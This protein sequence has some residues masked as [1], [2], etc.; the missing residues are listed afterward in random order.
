MNSKTRVTLLGRLRDG[1]DPLAWDEFFGRYW[2]L[3]YGFAQHRGCS[4]HTA[5]EIVQE[6][7]LKVFDQR[8]VFQ[9]DPERGRFR[10]WL[11]RLVRNHVAEYRRKPAQRIRAQGDL[12]EP[13][14]DAAG[15]DEAWEKAFEESLLMA[16]LEVVRREANPRDYLAFELFTLQELSGAEVARITGLTRNAVY[17]ARKRVLQRLKTLSGSYPS[18]GQLG[19]RVKQALRSQPGP[20]VE[21]SLTTRIEMTARSR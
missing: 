3:I 14:S 11:G 19:N 16:L 21:R 2:R 5:E 1:A 4:D 18:D 6:V 20:V 17:K 10:D 9:Y 15:P 7:M 13:P 12:T 8:D